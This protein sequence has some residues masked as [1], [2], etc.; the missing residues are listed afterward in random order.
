M[1]RKYAAAAAACA[2]ILAPAGAFAENY[3]GKIWLVQVAGANG[4]TRF[5]TDGPPAS[6]ISL[7]ATGDH[8]SVLL[9][10]FWRKA[11]VSVGYVPLSPCPGGITGTCGTVNFVSVNTTNF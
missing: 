9:E 8:E 11:T 5:H 3:V 10:A 7:Y 2:A 6:R 4:Q 1:L